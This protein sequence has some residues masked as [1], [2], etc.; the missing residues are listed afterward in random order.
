M[1]FHEADHFAAE[2]WEKWEGR[3]RREREGEGER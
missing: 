3:C 2:V 1:K